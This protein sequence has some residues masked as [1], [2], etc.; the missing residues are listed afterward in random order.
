MPRGRPSLSRIVIDA[1]P[2][3]I[4]PA[5]SGVSSV[6]SSWIPSGS[7]RYVAF[8]KMWSVGA[9]GTRAAA[10]LASTR[11]NSASSGRWIATW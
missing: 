10:I 6:S 1:G 7:L 8:E 5:R 11:A 3:V 9:C 4:S 2:T